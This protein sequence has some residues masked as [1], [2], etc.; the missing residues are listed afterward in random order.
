M[1]GAMEVLA[2]DQ[3]LTSPTSIKWD[4][5]SAIGAMDVVRPF[6]NLIDAFETISKMTIS[7]KAG[8]HDASAFGMA[9]NTFILNT[10]KFQER[11]VLLCLTYVVVS[12][13]S[14]F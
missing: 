6:K 11:F 5:L 10:K 14:T 7:A 1:V 13:C 2:K 12:G 9:I 4:V 8:T 3:V